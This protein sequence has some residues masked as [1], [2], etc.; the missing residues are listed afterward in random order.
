M[1]NCGH[2]RG[3]IAWENLEVRGA[4]PCVQPRSPT[5]DLIKSDLSDLFHEGA[6]I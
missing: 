3:N 5:A 1:Q 6:G 2:W 4:A